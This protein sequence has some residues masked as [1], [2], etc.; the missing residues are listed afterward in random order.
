MNQYFEILS[1]L[2]HKDKPL[3]FEKVFLPPKNYFTGLEM[4]FHLL[5]GSLSFPWHWVVVNGF[6]AYCNSGSL[7]FFHWV[8]SKEKLQ[9]FFQIIE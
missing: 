9:Q 6:L 3:Y 7:Q 5:T 1:L 2:F 4:A 8:A